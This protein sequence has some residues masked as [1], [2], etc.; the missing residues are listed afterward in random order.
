MIALTDFPQMAV[1]STKVRQALTQKSSLK[2]L[3]DD[4]VIAYIKANKLFIED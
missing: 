1:S 3:L 2:G 4:K